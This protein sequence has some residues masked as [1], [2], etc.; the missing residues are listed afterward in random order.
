M[1]NTNVCHV[2]MYV[3]MSI[4]IYIYILYIY[5]YCVVSYIHTYIRT[6]VR[7]YVRTDRQTERQTCRHTYRHASSFYLSMADQSDVAHDASNEACATPGTIWR[8]AALRIPAPSPH[9]RCWR[10]ACSVQGTP[11]SQTDARESPLGSPATLLV[12]LLPDPLVSYVWNR[13]GIGDHLWRRQRI[14]HMCRDA[15]L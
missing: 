4:C 2:C 9:W 14:P 3:C 6:Y 12:N 15:D 11:C 10:T 13:F 7:T 5:V 1:H 8:C